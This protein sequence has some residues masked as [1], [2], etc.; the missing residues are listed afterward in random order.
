[1]W[2]SHSSEII[3]WILLSGLP[4]PHF[5][6]VKNVM[7]GMTLFL[8]NY[9]DRKLHGIFEAVSAGQMKIDPRAWT[10]DDEEDTPFPAQVLIRV[11]ILI[12]L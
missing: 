8:F 10:L 6:Y 3:C 9:S 1:M 7:Q 4:A 12:F 11:Y 2:N 5:Q